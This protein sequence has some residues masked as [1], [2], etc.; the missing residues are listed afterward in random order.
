VVEVGNEESEAGVS[1]IYKLE[2]EKTTDNE[3]QK[4]AD[5]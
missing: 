5:L 2:E 4:M 1:G 3:R